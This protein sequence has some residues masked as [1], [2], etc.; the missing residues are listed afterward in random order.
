[1][2]NCTL[3]SPSVQIEWESP[4]GIKLYYGGRNRGSEWWRIRICSVSRRR[5]TRIPV[6]WFLTQGSSYQI[7]KSPSS[8]PLVG[9]SLRDWMGCYQPWVSCV[10]V[11]PTLW[12]R[13]VS[14]QKS[15]PSLVPPS[16]GSAPG[17]GWC[18]AG[19]GSCTR[20]KCWNIVLLFCNLLVHSFGL[21]WWLRQ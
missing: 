7:P 16:Q 17:G 14:K 15:L 18:W 12:I 9:L 8:V 6:S 1:M 21:R 11:W 3:K 5:G 13:M 10:C 19:L 4:Q 2:L 20:W